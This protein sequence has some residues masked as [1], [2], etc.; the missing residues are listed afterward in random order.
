MTEKYEVEL[1]Q[2]LY[3]GY[4]IFNKLLFNDKLPSVIITLQKSLKYYGYFIP[5]QYQN[6]SLIR[7]EIALNPEYFLFRT[8]N[9][10][11][12][13][14]VH[15][16]CH[17]EA[18]IDKKDSKNGYHNKYWVDCM[19]RCG[20]IPTDNGS[21]DGKR[22]GYKVSHIIEE[23]G[24]FDRVIEEE[25]KKGL[26]FNWKNIRFKGR[27]IDEKT[28]EALSSYKTDYEKIQA[29][30]K[31]GHEEMKDNGKKYMYECSCSKVWGKKGL[32]L[33]CQLC[34]E[35]FIVKG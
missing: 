19:I 9:E 35:P 11:Y 4:A 28:I 7:S 6:N 26:L 16:M 31:I 30:K 21:L 20:L 5:E 25:V 17:L 33:I 12:S 1:Y 13:T 10:T 22:T 8:I 23:G 24:L 3:Y 15:E 2:D 32:S 34:S 29:L 18:F 27:K 14:L